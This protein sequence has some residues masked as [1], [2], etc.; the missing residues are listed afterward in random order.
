MPASHAR[1]LTWTRERVREESE[2]GILVPV[3]SER[4]TRQELGWLLAQEA[5]GAAKALREG[6]TQLR[7]PTP[8]IQR[9]PQVE[10]TLDAL[11]GAIDLLSELETKPPPKGRRG[12]VD[13]AAMLYEIAPQARILMEPGA[14]TEVLGDELELRRMINVLVTQAAPGA[15]EGA[16]SP[17]IRVRRDNDQVKVEVVLGPDRPATVELE[18]RWLTRMALRLGGKLELEGG[19]QTLT[20]PADGVSAQRQVDELRKEL[21]QAQQL[22]EAYARELAE[23]FARGADL[24]SERPTVA[25]AASSC[26][27]EGL[28][29]WSGAMVQTLGPVLDSLTPPPSPRR[30]EPEASGPQATWELEGAALARDLMAD[31]KQVAACPCHALPTHCDLESLAERALAQVQPRAVRRRVEIIAESPAATTG[32]SRPG[33]AAMGSSEA[34][35]LL[36]AAILR[37]TLAQAEEGSRW[38]FRFDDEI[39]GWAV[40]V[41]RLTQSAPA[42]A[43]AAGAGRRDAHLMAKFG[44]HP[45][46]PWQIAE[47]VAGHLGASIRKEEQGGKLQRLSVHFPAVPGS[48]SLRT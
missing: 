24:A 43:T 3:S 33:S 28:I 1:R 32:D 26:P 7:Q 21:E 19:F 29:R 31:L 5:R 35:E 18:R 45:E 17:E 34:I 13:L 6:V 38:A 42:S 15:G 48:L 41:N 30:D 25:P 11:D 44:A 47:T 22:G 12:R 14:G 27:F 8:E 4:L 39:S 36:F 16:V 40:S 37:T 46:L 2:N 10:L 23:V 20:L 9:L